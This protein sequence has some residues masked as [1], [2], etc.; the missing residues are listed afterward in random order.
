MK[1]FAARFAAVLFGVALL[2][3]LPSSA[4]GGSGTSPCGKFFCNA[5]T[6]GCCAGVCYNFLS[7]TCVNGR[8]QNSPLAPRPTRRPPLPV[9]VHTPKPK[10]TPGPSCN[11][12][13]YNPETDIC[14]GK[15]ICNGA[16]QGC[17][18]GVCYNNFTREC[19][20]GR[21]E[22]LPLAPLPV[23]PRPHRAAITPR[24]EGPTCDRTPYNP[25]LEGCCYGT[26]YH[27]ATGMCCGKFICNSLT[28]G[29]CNGICYNDLTKM[30]VNGQIQTL[31]LKPRP[32]RPPTYP[33]MPT[34]TPTATPIPGPEEC[35]QYN[36]MTQGCCGGTIIPYSTTR[37]GC[38][39]I[40]Y[41]LYRYSCSNGVLVPR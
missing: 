12:T 16:T 40:V 38:C 2:L 21:I 41:G 19:V 22:K 20:N 14:C 1:T 3:V 34:A 32:T 6:Q 10:A 26:I 37:A 27:L 13:P 4:F 7:K 25:A 30:C 11:G 9:S 39:G 29:C 5:Y 8:I 24:P 23:K 33:P 31:P 18:A 15:F 36:T 28:Q 17:C 35:A